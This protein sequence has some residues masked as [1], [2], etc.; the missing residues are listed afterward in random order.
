MEVGEM[1]GIPGWFV[2]KIYFL[3]EDL[4]YN[5]KMM[6]VKMS[7]YIAVNVYQPNSRN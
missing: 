1:A 6:Y 2:F 4:F 3:N 5:L 7:K